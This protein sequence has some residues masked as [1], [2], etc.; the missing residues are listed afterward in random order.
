MPQQVNI[1]ILIQNLNHSSKGTF[2]MDNYNLKELEIGTATVT[3][4]EG[5][6]FWTIVHF[7]E[8]TINNHM[9]LTTIQ[10]IC[11][12]SAQG[13]SDNDFIVASS[14][15]DVYQQDQIRT[16]DFR[17]F[18]VLENKRN[19]PQNFWNQIYN[20]KRPIVFF[21]NGEEWIPLYDFN[22]DEALRI[23]SFKENSPFNVNFEGAGESLVDLFYAREREERARIDHTNRYLAD[24]TENVERLVRASQVINNPNTHPGVRMYAEQAMIK[25]INA[26]EKLNEKVGIIE[27]RIDRKA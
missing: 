4:K 24:M 2:I 13:V 22:K 9:K 14:S 19:N 27:V 12:L 17:E 1:F 15:I 3:G 20:L 23:T 25:I 16:E 26:Q 8:R 6:P 21:N 5:L 18:T 11:E 7:F 10:R